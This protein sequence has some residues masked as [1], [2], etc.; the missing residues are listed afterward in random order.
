[1]SMASTNVVLFCGGRGSK[2]IITELVRHSN[3]N[4]TL[5]VNAYDDGLSTGALRELIPGMLGPSDFRK[6]LFYL[7]DLYSK[8]QYALLDLF[9]Y[10]L[11]LDFSQEQLQGLIDYVFKGD[12]KKLTTTLLDLFKKI[13]VSRKKLVITYLQEFFTYYQGKKDSSDFDF[14]DCSLGNLIFAG[15]YL[16]EGQSFNRTIDKLAQVGGI[17]AKL[18]NVSKGECLT[19]AGL[20]EDGQLLTCE[21][22]V[23]GKQSSSKVTDIALISKPDDGEWDKYSNKSIT[24]KRAWLLGQ[25]GKVEVSDEAKR[26]LA[27]AD[28]IIYGSGTQHSS[29]LPSYIIASK[30]IL[31][32]PAKLKVLISNLHYDHDIQGLKTTDLADNAL[33]YLSDSENKQKGITH[34]LFNTTSTGTD[35]ISLGLSEDDQ[36]YKGAQ[37]IRGD[38]VNPSSP[39]VHSGSALAEEI[40]GLYNHKSS[41][42]YP[43]LQL[44]IDLLR[45]SMATSSFIHEAGEIH[46]SKDFGHTKIAVNNG[47]SLSKI[48][49]PPYLSIESTNLNAEGSEIVV[50]KKWLQEDSSDYLVTITGDGEYRLKDILLATEILKT[51]AF[52]AIYGSRVQSRKQF[53]DS[54]R[55]AY[56]ESRFMYTASW[57]GAFLITSL[58]GIRFGI[59]FSDPLTGFRIYKRSVLVDSGVKEQFLA[60]PPASTIEVTK[61]LLKNNIEIAEIPVQYRTFSG[62]TQPRWRF[63][64]G[65]KS[66]LGFFR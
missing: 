35:A 40:L 13:D 41:S 64:R 26:A 32:S 63:R 56:P 8:H 17:Q 28:I 43:T 47:E 20:K 44:F 16:A 34:V 49:T 55:S 45:R 38:F 48:K 24:E 15:I 1:M 19:L 5:L 36:T 3:I 51:G 52:G 46:W 61:R 54:L 21:A 59:F 23:V 10:R 30:E 58:F 4:L 6:N 22:E 50:L 27:Q 62:F 65:V 57:L 7:L 29:L 37:V 25:S 53:I 39:T 11:P 12:E 66:L 9:E 2:A 60:K 31:A 14:A 33:R 42:Q 18:V